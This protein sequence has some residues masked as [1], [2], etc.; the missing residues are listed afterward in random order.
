MATEMEEGSVCGVR[1]RSFQVGWKRW[2]LNRALKIPK[3]QLN[4]KIILGTAL[5]IHRDG[6]MGAHS[7]SCRAVCLDSGAE[8]ETHKQDSG[9]EV[10]P[11]MRSLVSSAK[12]LGFMLRTTARH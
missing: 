4:R 10:G 2:Y 11:I 1:W 12:G 5:T 9:E 6:E 8:G 7:R 3:S